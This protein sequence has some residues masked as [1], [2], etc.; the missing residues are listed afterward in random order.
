MLIPLGRS[1]CQWGEADSYRQKFV[2]MGGSWCLQ[3]EV[4]ANAGKLVLIGRNLRQWREGN[5]VPITDTK[6]IITLYLFQIAHHGPKKIREHHIRRFCLRCIF[7]LYLTISFKIH[8][9]MS[10]NFIYGFE[11]L[12]KVQHS[13]KFL[14]GNLQKFSIFEKNNR[15][16]PYSLIKFDIC[17]T[18]IPILTHFYETNTFV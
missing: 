11:D 4:C 5:L 10:E 7:L 9:L 2:S 18:H 13:L 14:I 16:P 1:L 8:I 17:L 12:R 3:V 6:R 15:V